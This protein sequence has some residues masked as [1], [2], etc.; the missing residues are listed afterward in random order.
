MRQC[1][2]QESSCMRSRTHALL[3]CPTSLVQ[4]FARL[5]SIGDRSV[6][7]PCLSDAVFQSVC[8]H[9]GALLHI[10]KSF[11]SLDLFRGTPSQVLSP[12]RGWLPLY[13][14]DGKVAQLGRPLLSFSPTTRADPIQSSCGLLFWGRPHNPLR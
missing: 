12:P 4:A 14:L 2:L 3:I 9:V 6:P 13:L 5:T 11:C 7:Y 8:L 1:S 10:C